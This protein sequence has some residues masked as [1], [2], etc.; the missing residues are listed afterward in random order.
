VRWRARGGLVRGE[1]GMVPVVDFDGVQRERTEEVLLPHGWS[2][3]PDG[4]ALYETSFRLNGISPKDTALSLGFDPGVGR[5]NLYLNGWL[6]GRHWPER[7][8]Q[9]RYWLPWGI[10]SA[11][12]ENH[13]AVALW[14]RG[15]RAALGKLRLEVG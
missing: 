9:R 10:L 15:K 1:A 5:G 6:I 12:G 3:S 14:K 7:G 4:V 11:D 2:G 13:L 8:P